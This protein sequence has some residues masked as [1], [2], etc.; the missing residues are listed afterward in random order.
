MRRTSCAGCGAPWLEVVLDLGSSP[1]AN[2]YLD[3]A[4]ASQDLKRY[5]IQLLRCAMCGLFQQAQVV[6]DIELWQADYAFYTGHSPGAAEIQREAARRFVVEEHLSDKLVVEIGCNDGT[7]LEEMR[8]TQPRARLVGVDPAAGPA[9]TARLLGL[10]V[11]QDQFSLRVAHHMVKDYGQADLVIGNNVAAHVADLSD[12]LAGVA[13]LLALDGKA[14]FE[15]QYLVD[16]VTGNQFD[17]LYHEH[18]Y[19]FTAYA[20]DQA[21]QRHNLAVADVEQTPAQ[22]GSIRVTLVHEDRVVGRKNVRQIFDAEAWTIV[23]PLGLQGRA[24]RMRAQIQGLLRDQRD[25]GKVVA[26]Y[27][28]SAKAA[29]LLNWC[30]IDSSLVR[31]VTDHTPAKFGRYIPGTD[32]PVISAEADSRAPDVY[33]LMVW[34]Y[35]S[36][37]LRRERE[38][39]DRGGRWLVP[40]PQVILI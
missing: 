12:F 38:F 5:S 30:E 29:T 1:V 23:S 21:A 22:G 13:R 25:V 14:V 20:F 33:L 19:F 11:I 34:S 32:I 3:S 40:V 24:N 15:V 8:A 28:A 35:L 6:P 16:L 9:D 4:V 18:R 10:D 39:M 37:I 27:G 31:Y 26:G 36:Q 2:T 17:H 7:L